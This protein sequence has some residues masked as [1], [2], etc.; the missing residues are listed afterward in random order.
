MSKTCRR[1]TLQEW[2]LLLKERLLPVKLE[3]SC[4][5]LLWLEFHQ[6][7]H[8]TFFPTAPVCCRAV[9]RS[10]TTGAFILRISK[11]KNCSEREKK[12][13]ANFKVTLCMTR[14]ESRFLFELH[15]EGITQVRAHTQGHWLRFKGQF[16]ILVHGSN[17]RTDAKSTHK[18][19]E[20]GRH[21]LYS[22]HLQ[23][24]SDPPLIPCKDQSREGVS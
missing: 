9:L 17:N 3:R 8:V 7:T 12:H 18:S 23:L 21:F 22:N 11:S 16:Q 13:S 20:K 10:K 4:T 14:A 19:P 15:Q 24:H 1:R 2:S 5:R 6:V